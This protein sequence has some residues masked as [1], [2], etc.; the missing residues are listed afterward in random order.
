MKTLYPPSLTWKLKVVQVDNDP[1]GP[2]GLLMAVDSGF[3]N[4]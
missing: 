2:W 4:S 3:L 1:A